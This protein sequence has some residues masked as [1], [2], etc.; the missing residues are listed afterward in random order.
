MYLYDYSR[1][2]EWQCTYKTTVEYTDY[3]VHIWV[4]EH[5]G[6]GYTDIRYTYL[7]TEA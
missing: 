7:T 3:N 1:I 2:Y 4:Q 5:I 6:L